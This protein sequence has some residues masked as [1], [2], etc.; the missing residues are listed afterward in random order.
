MEE[1]TQSLPAL[2]KILPISSLDGRLNKYLEVPQS[3]SGVCF[4]EAG[5]LRSYPP[6]RHKIRSFSERI[7]QANQDFILAERYAREGRERYSA[8]QAG[9][10]RNQF[11]DA[12][13]D[14]RL[15]TEAFDRS[16]ELRENSE[17]RNQKIWSR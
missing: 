5:D 15:A 17:I 8:A 2:V 4:S 13:I 10:N 1:L 9:F 6:G 14:I 3:R 12:R 16:L 7:T 11:E